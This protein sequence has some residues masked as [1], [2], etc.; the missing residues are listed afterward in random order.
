MNL[1]FFDFIF[2]HIHPTQRIIKIMA[3]PIINEYC[4]GYKSNKPL[5]YSHTPL[6]KAYFYLQAH[7]FVDKSR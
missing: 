6:T 1:N 7:E 5:S 2:L 3:P 4:Q